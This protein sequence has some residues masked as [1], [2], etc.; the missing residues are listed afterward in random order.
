M[1]CEH[2]FCLRSSGFLWYW[3]PKENNLIPPPQKKKNSS[4]GTVRSSLCCSVQRHRLVAC[5]H[6]RL[7]LWQFSQG[8]VFP[9]T[10][11]PCNASVIYFYISPC[12][13]ITWAAAILDDRIRTCGWKMTPTEMLWFLTDLADGYYQSFHLLFQYLPSGMLWLARQ[14][15]RRQTAP[16][17]HLK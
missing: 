5:H 17:N 15:K 14:V 6:G 13:K 1:T 16:Q 3:Y 2:F 10:M 11:P 4:L 8:M 9:P 7:N 12:F